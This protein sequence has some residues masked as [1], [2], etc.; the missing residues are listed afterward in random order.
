M[1]TEWELLVYL[2]DSI[3]KQG[4]ST[5]SIISNTHNDFYIMSYRRFENNSYKQIYLSVCSKCQEKNETFDSIRKLIGFLND[6]QD[7]LLT[8]HRE[9][10]INQN[11]SKLC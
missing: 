3:A 10:L 5:F 6:R 11:R 9:L 8:T 7:T 2:S 4:I 1:G